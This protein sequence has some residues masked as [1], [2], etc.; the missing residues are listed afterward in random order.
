MILQN[1]VNFKIIK[2]AFSVY[3]DDPLAHPGE[4]TAWY[5]GVG[6]GV[7]RFNPVF[8]IKR[9]SWEGTWWH[10]CDQPSCLIYHRP[11]FSLYDLYLRTVNPNRNLYKNYYPPS[12]YNYWTIPWVTAGSKSNYN[13]SKKLNCTLPNVF[14]SIC[15]LY[16]VLLPY[17]YI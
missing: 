12:L 17:S 3:F 6:G 9:P 16:V 2:W 14:E 11:A 13:S 8:K 15:A 4:G 7:Y 5:P 1:I 10:P